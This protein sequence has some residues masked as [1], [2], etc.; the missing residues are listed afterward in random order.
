MGPSQPEREQLTLSS[1]VFKGANK[2]HLELADAYSLGANIEYLQHV[3]D[4]DEDVFF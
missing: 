4:R 2:S 1:S 3:T